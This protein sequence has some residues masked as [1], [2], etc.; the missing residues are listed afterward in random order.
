MLDIVLA[1][2]LC[3]FNTKIKEIYAMF[4]QCNIY[5]YL[6]SNGYHYLLEDMWKFTKY[7]D[8]GIMFY[9]PIKIATVVIKNILGSALL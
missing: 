4:K 9:I 3:W 5:H 2:I 6:C 8:A 1:L 7:I